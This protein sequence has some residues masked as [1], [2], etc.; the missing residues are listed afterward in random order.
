MARAAVSCRI[1]G[2][3]IEGRRRPADAGRLTRGGELH[4]EFD[5][6]VWN[7]S[8]FKLSYGALDSLLDELDSSDAGIFVLAPDDVTVLRGAEKP[9]VRDNVLLELGMFIGRLGRERSYMITPTG[10]SVELPSDLLGLTTAQYDPGW[11]T[12]DAASA[13]GPA[14]TT[15]RRQ[16]KRL[17][18]SSRR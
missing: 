2:R 12:D 3:C 10:Q 16:F 8:D 4:D 14:C 9:T 5:I 1:P 13:I 7:Q 17:R 6:K 18:A 15:I 11:L